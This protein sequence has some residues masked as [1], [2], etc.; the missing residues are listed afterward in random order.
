MTNRDS[1][2]H[3]F[4]DL[5]QLLPGYKPL[6]HPTVSDGEQKFSLAQMYK[7]K[8]FR[9]YMERAIRS[10]VTG[11]QSVENERGLYIQQGRLSAL[12]ELYAITKQ[13]FEEADKIDK[14]IK[15]E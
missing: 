1:T 15:V 13:M 2:S 10:T 12:K 6:E 8:G 14:R 7:E 5:I 9:E 3:T 4:S 11:F